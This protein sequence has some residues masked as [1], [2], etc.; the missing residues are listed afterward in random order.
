ME[1]PKRIILMNEHFKAQCNYCPVLWMFH[2]RS[3]NNKINCLSDWCLR[4]I[5]NDRSG[6]SVVFLGKGVLKIC[7]RF[8]G[9][10]PCRSVISTKLLC[11]FIEITLRHWRSPVNLQH[12][13]NT[14]F[15][16]NTSGWLLLWWQTFKFWGT[17]SQ[18]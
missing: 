13:F 6:P 2:T 12:I 11:S 15:S 7:C 9:E 17:A 3:L 16:E 8:T 14:A 1:L 10:H 5:S 4:V 18:R